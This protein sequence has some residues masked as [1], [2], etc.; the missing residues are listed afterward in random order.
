MPL[1]WLHSPGLL[2]NVRAQ[3]DRMVDFASFA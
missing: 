2:V 1:N 3:L